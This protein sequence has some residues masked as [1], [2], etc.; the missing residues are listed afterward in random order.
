VTYTPNRSGIR[1]TLP[2]QTPARVGI[3]DAKG[4][5]MLKA[6]NY[7]SPMMIDLSDMPKGK[8]VVAVIYGPA[9]AM[10]DIEL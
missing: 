6:V 4:K 7:V 1:L 9:S 8:Y 10:R 3:F 5:K 2:D